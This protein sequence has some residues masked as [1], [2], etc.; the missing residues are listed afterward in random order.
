[1]LG[2][3]GYESPAELEDD[4]ALTAR[5]REIRVAAAALMGLGDAPTV[6][7]LSLL[8]P[9]RAGGAIS[10]RTFIPVRVHEAI[11]VLGAAGVAAGL[12]IPGT[13]AAA[14]APRPEPGGRVRVEHPTGFL[15]VEVDVVAGG[16]PY[17][18]RT[19][20]DRTARKIFDGTVYPG[21]PR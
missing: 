11:G 17:A 18:A 2:L 20:V 16:V 19:A 12:L 1:D 10:T 14:L 6:P 3:T 21:G 7:K 5:V 8:A 13:I 15:D 9:P 4:A